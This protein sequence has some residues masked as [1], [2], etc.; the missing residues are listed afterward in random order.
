MSLSHYALGRMGFRRRRNNE[1]LRTAFFSVHV[2]EVHGISP[3]FGSPIGSNGSVGG[4][5]YRLALAAT[6]NAAAQLVASDD[7]AD[8]EP[9]WV[10]QRKSSPPY[11]LIHVG[12]TTT[13]EMTGDFLKEEPFGIQTYDAFIPARRELREMESKVIPSVLSALSC[14]F[15]TLPNPVRFHE[16]ERAV[17][18]KT[19]EGKTVF[20][21]GIEFN[22]ELRVGQALPLPDLQDRIKR[23]ADLATRM[24]PKVSNFYYLALKEEDPLKRFLYL[25]LTIE[26]QTHAAFKATDHGSHMAGLLQA[27]AR[28]RKAGTAFFGT[29]HERWTSLQER[30]V[31]CALT[32][33]THLADDDVDN[34]ARVKKVRDQIAHGE[35]AA[36]PADAVVLVER[37]AAKLQLAPHGEDA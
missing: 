2:F 5:E 21:F 9:A 24:N 28:L 19:T 25:F 18:G 14:T 32:V 6:L 26:R 16:L 11:L 4:V 34:F 33:W 37:V 13:H 20:D 12:P 31:W 3:S 36:P 27:P 1:L 8:D 15:G 35:I 10:A 22:A 30:F 17:A 7:F 29:Q 23:A